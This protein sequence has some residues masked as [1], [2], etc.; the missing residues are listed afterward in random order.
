[1]RTYLGGSVY[2]VYDGDGFWL[3][4]DNGYGP[5]N[6][7]YLDVG[8]YCALVRFVEKIRNPPKEEETE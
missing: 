2:V 6:A 8:T 7:I 5:N 4:T 3:A 1:M